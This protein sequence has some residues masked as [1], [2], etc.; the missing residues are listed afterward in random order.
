MKSQLMSTRPG[1]VLKRL[2]T[3]ALHADE[4]PG[5]GAAPAMATRSIVSIEA[6]P[7]NESR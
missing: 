4:H 5:R 1:V 6:R 7:L 3:I 2:S